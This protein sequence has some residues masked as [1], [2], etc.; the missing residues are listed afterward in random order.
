[1]KVYPDE[2]VQD[3]PSEIN[4]P[5]IMSYL[6]EKAVNENHVNAL[7]SF[8]GLTDNVISGWLNLNVKTFREYRKPKTI[9]KSNTKEHIL[10]L[11][12]LFKHGNAVFGSSK[13]FDKW[14]STKNFY[15]DGQA[16]ESLLNTITGIRFVDSRLTAM[17][18][19]DNT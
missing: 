9:L 8:T 13:A 5:E 14:L 10:L 3:I 18:Y 15:F 11:L 16:P 12:A 19:G 7:H 4:E 1:M 2:V 6:Q 17:Q